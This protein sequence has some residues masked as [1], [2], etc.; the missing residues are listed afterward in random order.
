MKAIV[1]GA[2][3]GGLTT[4]CLLAKKGFQTKVFEKNESA[5][6]KMNQYCEKGYR[7]DTGPSLLTMPFILEKVFTTC[8]YSLSDYLELIPV[9]PVCRYFFPDGIRFDS[10][11]SVDKNLEQIKDF[12]PFNCQSFKEFLTYSEELFQHTKDNFLFNPLYDI[13][14]FS[15]LNLLNL[16]H[17][18][19]LSTLAGRVDASFQ[20]RHLQL[21]FKRFATYNGSSPYQAPATLNVIPYVELILGSYYVSGGMYKIAEALMSLAKEEGVQFQ[22]NTE[23]KAVNVNGRRASGVT[24]ACNTRYRAD[25][26]ISNSDATETYVNLLPPQTIPEG[27]LRLLEKNEPSCSAFVLLLGINRKFEQLLH[28]NIFFSTDY[29]GEFHQI[30][31]QKVMPDDPTI[32][33]A[34]TSFSDPSHAPEGGSNLFILVNAPWLSS[35]WNWQDRCEMYRY[36]I[37]QKLEKRGLEGLEESIEVSNHL[38]PVDFY[39]LYRS[40]K[41]SIYGTS[42]NSRF[43]A[44][45]RPRNKSRDVD[46]LYMVGGST[47]PGGGI[48]LVLLSAFH[49][50][51]LIER[52]E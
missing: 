20:S 14:D 30:F 34:D 40:N 25:L 45:I 7:F 5:G 17:I 21:F 43:A 27:R 35:E 46:G 18:D 19:A 51:E 22:F 38:T 8:G 15:S 36:Q 29:K 12:A 9:D 33:V 48:P 10:Y 6:G 24:T 32:Y 28:H 31:R 3:L 52:Y 23:I 42:S 37:I 4:A 39:Q 41:G 47:H 2:G 50:V 1:I 26:V 44:F 13:K 11:R 16:L 49:A